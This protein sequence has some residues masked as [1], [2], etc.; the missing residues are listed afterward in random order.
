MYVYSYIRGRLGNNLFQ[1]WVARY[2]ADE[3]GWPL[4]MYLENDYLHTEIFPCVRYTSKDCMMAHVPNAFD[5]HNI[6]IQC[7]ISEHRQ[8]EKPVLIKMYLEKYQIMLPY[9]RYIKFLYV[10]KTAKPRHDRVAI[11]MRFGDLAFRNVPLNEAY[12]AFATSI[13][14]HVRKDVLIISEDCMN[15]CTRAMRDALLGA[16]AGVNVTIKDTNS[17]TVMDDFEDLVCSTVHIVGNSTFSWWAGMLS[18]HAEAIHV[19]M[20]PSQQAYDA[21]LAIYDASLLPSTW[22][23]HHH[24]A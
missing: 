3:L 16:G 18:D 20:H 19:F 11:H 22:H 8:S 9:I 5:E 14:R 2:I 4:Y 17:G 15:I 10:R 7:I 21:R 24:Q 12:T 6:D 1:Y 13:V 23:I